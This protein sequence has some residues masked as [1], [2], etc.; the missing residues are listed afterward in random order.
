VERVI[1][2]CCARTFLLT[3]LLASFLAII[4][5]LPHDVCKGPLPPPPHVR[6]HCLELEAEAAAETAA[7]TEDTSTEGTGTDRTVSYYSSEVTEGS[8]YYTDENGNNVEYA[9]K[10]AAGNQ[11]FSGS[12]NLATTG[13]LIVCF[14]SVVA[15]VFAIHVG[16]RKNAFR[17]T[18]GPPFQLQGA[19]SRRVGA[20]SAFAS[21]ALPSPEQEMQGVELRQ[22]LSM[23]MGPDGDVEMQP[24]YVLA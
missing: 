18:R 1:V 6:A 11:V 8:Y 17:A 5:V 4:V 10:D 3:Q 16:Q 22:G 13:W 23:E 12:R 21:G 20:V 14:A 24:G 2:G 7:P 9:G 19:V 15:A